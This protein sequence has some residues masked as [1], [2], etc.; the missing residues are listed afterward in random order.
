MEPIPF[1][2]VNRDENS[3][4]TIIDDHTIIDVGNN[5]THNDIINDED[6]TDN[7]SFKPGIKPPTDD[8]D[9][10]KT[11]IEKPTHKLATFTAATCSEYF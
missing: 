10:T 1:G 11:F 2:D 9:C 6:H 5:G 7:A 3:H 4:V 8:E